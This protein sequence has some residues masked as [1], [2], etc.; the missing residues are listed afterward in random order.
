MGGT[1]LTNINF[2]GISSQVEYVDMMK[3]FLTILEQL[4]STLDDVE[5]ARVE[6]LT[7]QLLNQHSCFSQTW[8][9]LNESQKRKILDIIVCGKGIILSEKN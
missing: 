2:A 5:K 3:Y 8:R 9:I 6:K 4:A 1:G 7:L